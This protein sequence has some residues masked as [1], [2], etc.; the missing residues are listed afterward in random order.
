MK[1]ASIFLKLLM[2]AAMVMLPMEVSAE[3]KK[4]GKKR[5]K[6]GE[7]R[8]KPQKQK[9][10]SARQAPKK[11][12]RQKVARDSKP[13][14]QQVKRE[15]P[16]RPK[17]KQQAVVQQ[18]KTP[19]Q[20][21]QK[22][23]AQS[24]RRA[25]DRQQ[26]VQKQRRQAIVQASER[27]ERNERAN[28]EQKPQAE[29]K[30]EQQKQRIAD[31]R[32]RNDRI[33]GRKRD[34]QN[35]NDRDQQARREERREDRRDNREQRDRIADLQKERRQENREERRDNRQARQ[36]T[37]RER[38][39]RAARAEVRK[40]V[41]K[42]RKRQIAKQK[43]RRRDRVQQFRQNRQ[44]RLAAVRRDRQSLRATRAEAR[45]E[46]REEVREEIR[47]YWEDRADEVRDRIEDRY[48]D[49]FD[50][51]WWERRRWRHR[52][53]YVSNPWWWWRPARWG[54]VNVFLDAGWSEPVTYDYGTDVV[55]DETTVYVHGEPVGTPVQYSER[56][57]ELA[58][59]TVAAVAEAPI[60]ENEWTP[61]G[62]WA[63]VQEDQGDA[64]MFFQLS[65][66]KN[67]IISGAYTNVVSG[68]ELPVTGQVDRKSQ[69]AAWHIGD[70][71]QKV[72]EAGMSNLTQD[73]ASVLVHNAPGEMQNWLLVRM[74][75]PGLPDQPAAVTT[76]AVETVTP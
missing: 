68:E 21:A 64:V 36:E 28:R 62:V 32:D 37:A 19:A 12:N 27:R 72:F 7:V 52:P 8:K 15:A 25:K 69:R 47:D 58:N 17:A 13:K 65:V 75:S 43:E 39:Q 55:Y 5:A 70:N 41:A 61:L 6:A 46:Y 66:D 57:I 22:A 11:Q 16:K 34:G 51:D 53:I 1:I 29:R 71:T 3:P 60:V 54:T 38:Q 44:R 23:Q 14:R 67:G 9:E 48:D 20:R 24:Q 76:S 40:K 42:D 18:R 63:L 2:A 50:D 74:E 33:E 31:G 56:V 49:L 59:P 26:Q 35:A 45:R 30:A 10:R 4:E 73:Q